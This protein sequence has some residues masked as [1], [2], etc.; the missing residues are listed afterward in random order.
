MSAVNPLNA[1]AGGPAPM[2]P[3]SMKFALNPRT[4]SD[5]AAYKIIVPASGDGTF[6][7]GQQIPF[8][9]SSDGFI[10]PGSV[11]F[12]GTLVM[13]DSSGLE[14]VGSRARAKAPGPWST[15]SQINVVAGTKTVSESR[16][17]NLF[18]NIVHA[19]CLDDTNQ[20][21][22]DSIGHADAYPFFV[23]SAITSRNMRPGNFGGQFCAFRPKI[24]LC[25]QG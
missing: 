12:E 7:S 25:T 22:E 19:Y 9:F 23:R 18:H 15:I 10:E 2:I 21:E 16:N 20:A 11:Q 3:P 8:T 17:Y 6:K 24:G 1:S 4:T 5:A 13:L 14:V